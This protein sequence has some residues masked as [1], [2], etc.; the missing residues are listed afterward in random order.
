[1]TRMGSFV[2]KRQPLPGGINLLSPKRAKP[3]QRA[4]NVH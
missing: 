4:L 3:D 1:M 2:L